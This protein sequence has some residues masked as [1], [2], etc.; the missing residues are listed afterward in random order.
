MLS[1]QIF[2]ACLAV[3]AVPALA[4]PPPPHGMPVPR[5]AG[6]SLPPSQ[7]ARPGREKASEMLG[8]F[9]FVDVPGSSTTQAL[10][11]NS[12]M[13][14]GAKLYVAGTAGTGFVMTAESRKTR[15][16]EIYRT[17]LP[18]QT[19]LF[20]TGVNDHQDV[21]GYFVDAGNNTHG[22]ILA[23]GTFTQLDVPFASGLSTV[24]YGIN[25]AGEVVGVYYPAGNDSPVEGFT[26]SNGTYAKIKSYPQATGTYAEGLNNNGDIVGFYVDADFGYHG[27]ILKDGKF[28]SYD[29]PGSIETFASA[30]NDDDV[31][32]GAFCP[33]DTCANNAIYSFYA[34]SAGNFTLLTLPWVNTYSAGQL[35]T[36][37]TDQGQISGFYTDQANLMHGFLATPSTQ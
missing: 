25:N 37:I 32:I 24:A 11:V 2:A 34:Y 31:A 3:T 20:A 17:I 23:G 26:Y 5:P 16:S 35:V 21:A 18:A 27:F 1:R 7:A 19:N 30:I 15:A 8:E 9:V 10:G 4:S 6:A 29:P 36:G 22:F 13:T 14:M 12:G 28:T 33:D